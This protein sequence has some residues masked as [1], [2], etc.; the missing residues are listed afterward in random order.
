MLHKYI[1]QILPFGIQMMSN[2]ILFVKGIR[3]ILLCS[4]IPTVIHPANKLYRYASDMKG[5][6][7]Q[8]YSALGI[9]GKK[10]EA[11]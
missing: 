2:A 1:L 4:L 7:K 11:F 5:K 3:P 6:N 9:S 8:V 10:V